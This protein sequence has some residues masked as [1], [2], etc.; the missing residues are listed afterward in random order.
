M[1]DQA[2]IK[3]ISKLATW[4]VNRPVAT[5]MLVVAVAVFGFI[6]Y[7]L[8]P[9][10]LL[11]ELSY[12][13]LTVRTELA[14]AAPEEV[15]DTV[16]RR[17]EEIVRTVEGVVGVR[18]VSRAGQSDVVLQFTWNSDMDYATQKVRERVELVPLPE[19]AGTPLILRYDP[20]LDPFMRVGVAGTVSL[21]ELR[22]ITEEDIQRELE[23]LE[24]VAMV[25]VRGGL[26]EIFRVDLDPGKMAVFGITPAAVAQRLAS[27]NINVAGGALAEGD[28]TYLV[29]TLNA[30]KDQTEI[31]NLIVAYPQGT[32]VRLSQV[33]RVWRDVREREVI[34]RIGQEGGLSE[35]IVVEIYKEADANM[36]D[37]S[38][39]VRGTLFGDLS[40]QRSRAQKKAVDLGKHATQVAEMLARKEAGLPATTPTSRPQLV[41][42]R[43]PPTVSMTVLNDQATFI[44]LSIDEVTNTAMMGGLFAVLVLFLFLRNAWSTL[45]IALSIPL[46]VVAAFGALRLAGV[47]LNVMSLGGIALG[48]GMLVDN[49]IVVLESIFRCREEGDSIFDAALRGTSEVAGAV[50]AS[51]TTTI[52][53]FLPIVFVDGIAGQIFGDLALSVVFSLLAS[54]VVAIYFVPVLAAREPRGLRISSFSELKQDLSAPLVS[55]A[56]LKNDWASIRNSASLVV[57]VLSPLLLVLLVARTLVLVVLELIF[58]RLFATFILMGVMSFALIFGALIFVV[59]NLLK[60][61]FNAFDFGYAKL[62]TAYRH[63]L[64]VALKGRFIIVGIALMLFGW[65]VVSFQNLG[66]ELLPPMHQGEFLVDL[67]MPVGTRLDETSRITQ[68]LEE[69]L[70]T[71]SEIERF[72]TTVGVERTN[73]QASDEGEHTARIA[74]ALKQS[75]DPEAQERSAMAKVRELA[76]QT[77]GATVELSRPSLFSTQ[78]PLEVEVLGDD[79]RLLRLVSDEV[80]DELRNIPALADVRSNLGRGFPEVQI[81]FKR[82]RLAAYGLTALDVGQVVRDQVRG[83]EPTRIRQ[84]EVEYGIVVRA[85]RRDIPDVEALKNLVIKPASEDLPEIRLSSVAD[86]DVAIGPSEIRR[87]QGT[88]AAV[89]QADIPI[90][91]ISAAGSAVDRV[92]AR[93]QPPLGITLETGGQRVEME[94]AQQAMLFAL[95]LAIFLVY[96]VLAS[97]FESLRGP[98]VILLSIPLALIGVT[99]ALAATGTHVSILVFIGMIML[100]G[101]VVNNA[102]VLVD[103]INQLRDRGESIIEATAHACQIRLRP[104]LITTL[105]TV[106]GLLPMALGL[107]E[108]AEL[109]TPLAITVIAGLASATLLTLFVIPS[110]Y[111]IA[112][113]KMT[114][115][116]AE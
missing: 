47:S 10:N 54:L 21:A 49:S 30:F 26:E 16:T 108:G 1:T 43:L 62:A 84:G 42:D 41:Y 25:K 4:S 99:A 113:Q 48:I 57:R 44:E 61:P 22:R 60:M 40:I 34:T 97:T 106:L 80:A 71:I 12:P 63:A 86:L 104:V 27:E 92:L 35:S 103:Y 19:D 37:V 52:A 3:P 56:L 15:E 73:I 110:L 76:R 72:A 116:A 67:K 31:E 102:I 95:L 7:K 69:G 109:R 13:T 114:Q 105:T 8:L 36:V 53:V 6:S 90:T 11:P 51:T 77:P 112:M 59:R 82:E 17:L 100:S 94:S 5:L 68:T 115:P 101:I 45:I 58:A 85:A 70:L 9:V 28:V 66:T 81:R 91:S 88:R 20:D 78:T 74:V 87:I 2:P 98:F 89:V 23:K 55:L 46:S 32:P 83:V 111:V 93:I 75:Q 33:A 65:S 50:T 64:D 79:L 29:R 38:R 107:G 14:G 18:S 24:G 39:R 96:V